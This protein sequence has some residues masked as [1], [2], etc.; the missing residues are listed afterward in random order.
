MSKRTN[1]ILLLGAVVGAFL[2]GSWYT[3]RKTDNHISPAGSRILY[4][5]DPMHPAYKSDKPG[6]A[7]DC[8]MQLE[9]VYADEGLVTERTKSDPPSLPPGTVEVSPEKQQLTGMQLVA[10]E[11][12]SGSHELRTVGRVT[13][14]EDRIY[15]VVAG[16]DGWVRELI[17]GGTTGSVVQKD[18]L[19]AMTYTRELLAAEQ[20]YFYTLNLLDGLK[21]QHTDSPQQVAAANAQ[22]RTTEDN[23]YALGMSDLQ[24][25][26]IAKSRKVGTDMAIRAPV[27]G[28]VVARATYPG[29]RFDRGTELYRLVDLSHVWILADLFENETQYFRPGVTARVTIPHQHKTFTSRVSN[30][31]PQFDPNTRTLKVR[32]EADNPGFVLRPDMFVDV[33]L[34]VN[35]PASVTV[36][37]EA[38]IDSG[39]RKTVYVNRGNGFFEP[40]QVET[41]WQFGDR[42]QILKGLGA[43]ESIVVSGNFLLDSES[44]MKAVAQRG[45]EQAQHKAS[46]YQDPVCGM[47]IDPAKSAG[48]SEYRGKTYYF[49]SKMCKEKFDKNPEQYVGKTVNRKVL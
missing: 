18:Q 31:P 11:K 17:P 30:V 3:Q 1:V 35:L 44:R 8:G 43:G 36:P 13:A 48:K 26:E 47:D 5:H 49:C 21:T 4:Y 38:V 34:P 28:L 42:I 24:I 46:V 27:T 2:T 23:L 15:R 39:L 40:R 41:G 6:I 19:L 22:I 45:P 12:T 25:Q 29:L 9:P 14:N 16:T 37:V 7:P 20:T 33:E 10:V 32:L